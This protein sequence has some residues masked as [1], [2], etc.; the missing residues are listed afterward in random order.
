MSLYFPI[1]RGTLLIPSGTEY[2]PN[3]KH[4][5]VILTAPQGTEQEF[6]LVNIA[7]RIEP[8]DK[9]CLLSL[10]DHSFITRPSYVSY[11]HAII[12]TAKQ[13]MD[14]VRD[15]KFIHKD[16][17][18]ENVFSRICQGLLMSKFVAPNK[19]QF[20]TKATNLI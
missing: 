12:L 13:I 18:N 16:C 10:G 2:A 9:A 1:K 20:F 8:H 17:I 3:K 4:L 7:S 14:G 11:R 5:F 15:G 6:L 19:L